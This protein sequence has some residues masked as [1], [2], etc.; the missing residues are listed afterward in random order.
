[1]YELIQVGSHTYYIQ[2]PTRVGI[3]VRENGEAYLI[4]GGNDADSAKK[5]KKHL[6]EQ[7]WSLRGVLVTHGHAD[8]VG[9]CAWLQKQTGCKVFAFG[10]ERAMSQWTRLNTS[11]VWGSS[12]Y[13]EQE[14]K[15][16]LAPPSE[17][18]E[19]DDPEFPREVE[20]L[21][22]HGH[23]FHMT[24]FRTP[25]GTVFL[26]DAVNSERTL[27]KYQLAFVYDVQA[28]LDTLDRLAVMEAS[29]FVGAH[30]EP[31]GDIVPLT[32]KNRDKVYEIGA[33]ILT[34]CREPIT[35]EELL[36][37]MFMDYCLV[38]NHEQ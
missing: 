37:Q 21:D 26:G 18:S 10:V 24:G 25:D 36:R 20:V 29:V 35:F 30:I 13:R 6:D 12:L 7:G 34:L 33:H 8:H 32:R 23:S 2:S 15:F 38:M 16:L 3:Y 28:F 31:T 5:A 1:M 27:E 19:T 14:H 11:L 9:G 22:L 17:V 4:D